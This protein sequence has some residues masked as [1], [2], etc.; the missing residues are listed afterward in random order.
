MCGTHSF[1]VLN[2]PLGCRGIYIA[3]IFRSEIYFRITIG[4]VPLTPAAPASPNGMGCLARRSALQH[5]ASAHLE[6]PVLL[7][8]SITAVF[9]VSDIFTW[10]S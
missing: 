10:F 2:V 8:V 7:S 4:A 3:T 9:H 5:F 1:D 6:S